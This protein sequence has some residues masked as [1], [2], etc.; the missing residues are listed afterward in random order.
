MKVFVDWARKKEKEKLFVEK[1][2]KLSEA[3]FNKIGDIPI[4]SDVYI[5]RGCPHYVLW[6]LIDNQC[7]IWQI[8]GKCVKRYRDKHNLSKDHITDA[9]IIYKLHKNGVDFNK[10]EKPTED[11]IEYKKYV[12]KYQRLTK[13]L[14]S[15]K[16][17][18]GAYELEFNDAEFLNNFI[19]KIDKKRD[20]CI[21]KARNFV[22]DEIKEVSKIKGIGKRS[23][24]KFLAE[25]HPK[26]FPTLSKYLIYCG[27]KRVSKKSG[28]Y[29]HQASAYLYQMTMFLI[30]QKNDRYYPFYKEV[31]EQIREDHPDYEKGKID[32]MA[33]NRVGTFLLKEIYY[34]VRDEKPP[35]KVNLITKVKG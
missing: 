28:K 2:G 18:Q 30:M 11:E 6:G 12:K 19:E 27:R 25:A 1:E 26:N 23:V 31:K 10:L 33:R 21:G 15:I 34:R 29:N 22:S 9:K 35:K 13:I 4:N 32:G 3:T 14:T 24:I 7:E 16:N 20:E 17:Q 5:E 8:D